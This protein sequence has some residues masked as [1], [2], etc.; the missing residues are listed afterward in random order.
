MAKKQNFNYFEAFEKLSDYA[1][2]E[3]NL[4]IEA[5]DKFS[6]QGDFKKLADEAH[7][8]EHSGDIVNHEIFQNIAVEF[9]TPIEREDIISLAQNLDSVID[10]IEDVFQCLYM[11]NVHEIDESAKDFAVIIKE[12]CASLNTVMKQFSNYKKSKNIHE[13]I[14]AVN[15]FEEEGD[16][17]YLKA[18][19]NMFATKR[20]DPTYL[21]IWNNI[22]SKLEKCCDSCEHVA[23][24]VGT[25]LLKNS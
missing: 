12:S 19:H 5:F 18:M 7:E 10:F 8:I 3:A 2:Q 1:C 15:D 6:T 23:D 21:L 9:I 13:G 17:L 4:L 14:V 16:K 25:V 11:Y 22:F 20:D 24:L